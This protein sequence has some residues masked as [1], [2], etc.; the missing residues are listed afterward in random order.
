MAIFK[1][2]AYGQVELNQVA[3]RRDGRVEAQAALST[4]D[5]A[6]A[7]CENGMLLAVDKQANGG[8]GEV[9]FASNSASLPIALV[10]SA[11]HMYDERKGAL[12]DYYLGV[13][14]GD[15]YPRLGYLSIGDIFTTDCVEA[16]STAAIVAAA[17]DASST[18]TFGASTNGY[19]AAYSSAIGGPVLKCVKDYTMPDGTQGFKFQVIG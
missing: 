13:D 11:E 6:S 18:A 4:V 7:K 9:K 2:N 3:F 14:G 15:F 8:W 1:S 10:Y 17:A 5:F 12:R 16:T 19:I